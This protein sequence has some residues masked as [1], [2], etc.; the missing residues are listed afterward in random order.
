MRDA[1]EL[2][3]LGVRVRPLPGGELLYVSADQKRAE[4]LLRDRFGADVTLDYLGAS[5]RTLRA[6]PFGSWLAEG[7]ALHL[8]YALGHNG[9]EPGG[10]VIV[11][12]DDCILVSLS[13]VDWLGPRTLVRGFTPS[14][15][16]VTLQGDPCDRPVVDCFDNRVRPHWTT[17]EDA[18][19]SQ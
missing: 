7:C 16:T 14:H 6:H 19:L 18:A 10:C 4:Q 11:E 2:A 12:R 1:A 5:L 9:E 3:S 13:I 8:F 15:A 17:V